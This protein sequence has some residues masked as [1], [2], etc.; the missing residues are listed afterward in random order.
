M[1]CSGTRSSRG[2]RFL[3]AAANLAA[4]KLRGLK[5][6]LRNP[7]LKCVKHGFFGGLLLSDGACRRE[8][9]QR[10]RGHGEGVRPLLLC[11]QWLF[12]SKVLTKTWFCLGLLWLKSPRAPLVTDHAGGTCDHPLESAR[13]FASRAC[14]CSGNRP[15]IVL[16]LVLSEAR[17]HVRA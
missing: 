10:H 2:D 4:G 11:R 14:D 7:C 6:P 17:N 16:L 1:K 8:K 3:F 5:K 15:H 9:T 13:Q 12:V